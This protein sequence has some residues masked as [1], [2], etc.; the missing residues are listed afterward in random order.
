M[1][2]VRPKVN[3]IDFKNKTKIN[4]ILI[5]KKHKNYSG[6][7]EQ[8]KREN[9]N[10]FFVGAMCLCTYQQECKTFLPR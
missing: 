5:L 1:R 9:M 2:L 4:S 10:M 3:T 7:L 6:K 8:V